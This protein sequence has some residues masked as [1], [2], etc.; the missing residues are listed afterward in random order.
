LIDV[1][2][3]LSEVNGIF[4]QLAD[5]DE[6]A[7]LVR[8]IRIGSTENYGHAARQFLT[9]YMS[10]FE[11]ADKKVNDW[12]AAFYRHVEVQPGGPIGRLA[13]RFALAYAAA[14]LARFYGVVPWSKERI[15][16]AISLCYSG[17]LNAIPDRA[18]LLSKT[19]DSVRKKLQKSCHVL[20]MREGQRYDEEE[21]DA[22][23]AYLRSDPDEGEFFAVKPEALAGWLETGVTLHALGQELLAR[24]ALLV[25]A[26]NLPT[27]QVKIKGVDKKASYYCVRK[28][29]VVDA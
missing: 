26:R 29:F 23:T 12:I 10:A 6:S 16:Q 20:D 9:S 15:L 21:M 13:H 19:I 11:R 3:A 7:E 25:Q 28:S 17:A 14:R 4:D 24:N 5:Q 8:S 18:A 22:A 1:P 27:K 2:A